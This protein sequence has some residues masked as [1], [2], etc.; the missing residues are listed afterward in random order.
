MVVLLACK[1]NTPSIASTPPSKKGIII[2]RKAYFTI[3]R[4]DTQL[5]SLYTNTDNLSR[6]RQLE[7]I[8]QIDEVGSA[9]DTLTQCYFLHF[10]NVPSAMNAKTRDKR[11]PR[12][13]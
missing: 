7:E 5:S 6:H 11:I 9:E 12:K 13:L 2:T 3:I 8:E 10:S 4:E 1:V